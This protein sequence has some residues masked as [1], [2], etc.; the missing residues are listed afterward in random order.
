MV[1]FD[2]GDE[3]LQS[4]KLN[5]RMM[6]GKLIEVDLPSWSCWDWA[7]EAVAKLEGIPAKRL[8]LFGN[9]KELDGEGPVDFAVEVQ[10]VVLQ[11]YMRDA[12]DAVINDD[13]SAFTDAWQ[14][15]PHLNVALTK[16]DAQRLGILPVKSEILGVVGV[17][18]HDRTPLMHV[19]ALRGW[20]EPFKRNL[21]PGLFSRFFYMKVPAKFHGHDGSVVFRSVSC[22]SLAYLSGN[23]DMEAFFDGMSPDGLPGGLHFDVAS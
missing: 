13:E 21:F 12:L 5:I 6:S 18:F 9:G 14:H 1:L 17:S 19:V 20:N 8:K 3:Y 11:D 7:Q 15:L 2:Y 16:E 4:H 22:K 10:V 23:A